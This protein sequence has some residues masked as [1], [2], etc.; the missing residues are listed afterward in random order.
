MFQRKIEN[1]PQKF[2]QAGTF[3]DDIIN[4]KSEPEY[5]KK[6][7]MLLKC[8]FEHG[9][10]LNKKNSKLQFLNSAIYAVKFHK[11]ELNLF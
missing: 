1:I 4:D 9:I 10:R 7:W 5:F 6:S 3:L 11:K 2:D 8:F